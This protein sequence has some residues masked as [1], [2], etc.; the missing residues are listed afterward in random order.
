MEQPLATLAQ[1]SSLAADGY[2]REPALVGSG[3]PV[4]TDLGDDGDLSDDGLV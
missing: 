4:L 2:P 1:D 3:A